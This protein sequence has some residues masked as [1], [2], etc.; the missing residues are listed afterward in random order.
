MTVEKS[1]ETADECKCVKMSFRNLSTGFIGKTQTSPIKLS[2]SRHKPS[3][4]DKD[5]LIEGSAIDV[6]SKQ[7]NNNDKRNKSSVDSIRIHDNWKEKYTNL[8][9]TVQNLRTELKL[10]VKLISDIESEQKLQNERHEQ[11]KIKLQN[12][13]ESLQKEIKSFKVDF[14]EKSKSFEKH[15]E[16]SQKQICSLQGEIKSTKTLHANTLSSL[17]EKHNNELVILKGHLEA[18]KLKIENNFKDSIKEKNST[19]ENLKSKLAESF[20]ESSKERQ[21]QID[22]LLKELERVSNEAEYV[23][24]AL[25]NLKYTNSDC[26][27]CT[28]YEEKL[29][30]VSNDLREKNEICKNLYSVCSKMEKQLSQQDD[31]LM[32]WNRIKKV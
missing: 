31:L 20:K 26:K 17:A 27:K 9:K 3:G 7:C 14:A 8:Q 29:Q 16:D 21:I 15:K 11:E 23:K 24:N 19:I 1:V 10:K 2:Y 22:E 6:S 5:T 13:V 32:I 12:I 18:E 28:L 30:E 25:K 4:L